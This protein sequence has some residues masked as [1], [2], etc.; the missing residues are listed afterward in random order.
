MNLLLTYKEAIDIAQKILNNNNFKFNKHDVVNEVIDTGKK[1][2]YGNILTTIFKL[3]SEIPIP[4]GYIT[5]TFEK[6][7]PRATRICT[8]CGNERP[9]NHFYKKWKHREERVKICKVCRGNYGSTYRLKNKNSKK[10]K[11]KRLK[12]NNKYRSKNNEKVR[13]WGRDKA[14]RQNQELSDNYIKQVI[15]QNTKMERKDITQEMVDNK[16]K[17]LLAKRNK[18]KK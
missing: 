10:W 17:E 4:A 12:Y 3:Q 6:G 15:R 18:R 16:K 7:N 2:A 8:N 13:K 14:K 9:I 5:S 1:L 11:K